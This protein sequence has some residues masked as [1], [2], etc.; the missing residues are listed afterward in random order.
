M[1]KE[2]I[3]Q[4][5]MRCEAATP[6][7]WVNGHFASLH[8][9]DTNAPYNDLLFNADTSENACFI[10][11]ARQDIPALLDALEAETK[12]ADEA[13]GILG[14]V[15]DE[16]IRIGDMA[17]K[18][19][20]DGEAVIASRDR[21]KSRAEALERAIGETDV[22]CRV[23]ANRNEYCDCDGSGWEFDEPRFSE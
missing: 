13:E 10:A 21:W 4:I 16:N 23:C 2:R 3:S 20:Q 6:G 15:L 8:R 11:H 18:I 1:D 22:L 12:K 7:P 14:Y 19:Q 17:E 5:R 9:R